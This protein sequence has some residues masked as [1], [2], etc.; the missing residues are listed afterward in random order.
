MV[1]GFEG[2]IQI[3]QITTSKTGSE[4][5]MQAH[6]TALTSNTVH[7]SSSFLTDAQECKWK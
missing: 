2:L 3:W 6:Y 5:K 4:I 1:H 7:I